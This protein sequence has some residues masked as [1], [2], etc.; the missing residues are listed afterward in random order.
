[1]DGQV[2][3]R[4]LFER[5]S[6]PIEPA[7]GT[8][9]SPAVEAAA[10]LSTELGPDRPILGVN[11]RG[12]FVE[13]VVADPANAGQQ[14]VYSYS[15]GRVSTRINSFPLDDG[16]GFLLDDARLTSLPA[17]VRAAQAALDFDPGP[18][19]EAR[20]R[21]SGL[22]ADGPVVWT[23][24]LRPLDQPFRDAETEVTVGPDGAVQRVLLP[25]AM[26]PQWRGDGGAALSEALAG[27]IASLGP[28][29]LVW[30]VDARPDRV[31]LM[32]PDPANPQMSNQL[33]VTEE[34]MRQLP[35]RPVMM[36]TEDD[37][38]PL[39]V[40]ARLT[41]EKIDAAR[42][43]GLAAVNLPDGQPERLRLWSGAPLWRHPEGEPFFDIRVG[44]PSGAN[45][46]GVV[47]LDGQVVEA[48]R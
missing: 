31:S 26:R 46:Y 36:Q 14:I 10:A 42:A 37:L 2:T 43:A 5:G 1:M 28:D 16:P 4:I 11:A 33:V 47:T 38:F 34:G 23:V 29:A 25:V 35:G 6:E 32:Y 24:V 41:P 15:A 8:P 48:F 17:I 20:A 40:L 9:V 44:A 12:Q 21:R 7:P 18:P 39:S 19:Y 3:Q 27:F 13:V 45:G 30:E 22:E